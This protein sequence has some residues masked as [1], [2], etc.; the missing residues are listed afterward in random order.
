VLYYCFKGASKVLEVAVK[1]LRKLLYSCF[2][3][4]FNCFKAIQRCLITASK[5]LQR[6]FATASKVL[7]IVLY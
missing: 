7:Q 2:K 4:A 3:G 6:C 1:L 5:V